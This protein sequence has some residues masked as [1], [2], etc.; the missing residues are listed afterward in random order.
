[1][2]PEDKFDAA[3][4]S[5]REDRRALI[6]YLEN[7]S[8]SQ[9]R[10][11]PPQGGPEGGE[12]SIAQGAEHILL[13]DEFARGTLAG[14]LA[15]AERTGVWKNAP[16]N[17]KKLRSGQLRRREQGQVPS[18]EHLL[19]AGGRALSEMTPLLMPSPEETCAALA[20]YRLRDLEHLILPSANYG[21]LNIYDRMTYMGI[22]DALHME[23]MERL[24]Q[25]PGFPG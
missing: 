9:A 17:P 23:Q 1:M 24:E 2:T 18:P 14:M 12:W 5:A 3:L 4:A 16:E 20:P 10:W 8:D 6:A 22:H 13:T 7:F 25:A 15:E 11:E 19:P 21:D